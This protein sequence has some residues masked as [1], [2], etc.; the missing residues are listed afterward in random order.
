MSG[1]E[2][3][4]GF[5]AL[6]AVAMWLGV[7][8]HSLIVYKSKAEPNWPH[9]SVNY[10]FLDWLYDYIHVFRMPLFY[11]VAGFFSRMVIVKSGSRYF[12][13]QRLRRIVI[14]FVIG[15][16]VIVP[17]SLFPFHFNSFYF[18]QHLEV[19]AAVKKSLL[20]MF[21][22]NGL[23]HLWFL[24]YLLYFYGAA[25]LYISVFKQRI[26]PAAERITLFRN[27]RNSILIK[28]AVFTVM[29]F[30]ILYYFRFYTPPVYT[31]IRPNLIYL[32]YYGLFFWFGW[33]MQNNTGEMKSLGKFAWVLFIS[34]S[35]LSLIHFVKPGIT[36]PVAFVLV[37]FETIAL[38]FGMTGL[39]IKYLHRESRWWRYFSDASYWVYLIHILIVASLQMIMLNSTVPGF[40]RMP[41]VL[42][43]T[44]IITIV[45]YRYFVRYTIIGEYLHG[46]RKKM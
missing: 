34:G 44:F 35:V 24:Y 9:D 23:A 36:P 6:R 13:K 39:F 1:N 27:Y 17:L 46:K 20:Q 32:L 8:L 26:I 22:W 2:R 16:I 4:N 10:H 40:L 19:N 43:V 41:I 30:F 18:V 38:V 42:I 11:L 15:V 12:I 14:P 37:S 31:G 33:V 45:T 7:V 21:S 28:L 3:I 29:L 25:L 5:D